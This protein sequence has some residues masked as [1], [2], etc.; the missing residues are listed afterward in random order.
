MKKTLPIAIIATSVLGL[1]SLTSCH[2]EDFD[3]STTV[4][5]ERAFEQSF[6]K[7]FGQ[8]S[9]DQS[10]DF[11]AQKM[12]ALRQNAGLTRATQ[13]DVV[14]VDT[15]ISQPTDEWFTD[16]VD[17]WDGV[18]EEKHDNH[19]VGQNS[20][21]LTSTGDFKIYAVR[22]AGAIE[23]QSQYNLDFGIAYYGADKKRVFVPIFDGKYKNKAYK[24][25][26]DSN[27]WGNPGKAADVS[28]PAGQQFHFYLRYTFPFGGG[29]AT[30]TETF[31]SNESPVFIR[32]DGTQTFTFPE[33][34]GT[35]T[36]LYSTE[37][38]VPSEHVD[39]QVMMIGLE[40]AWG[41]DNGNDTEERTKTGWFDMDFNDIVVI[42]V[43][44]LP[45]P[46][47]KR[48]FAEDLESYDYD[49]ND[50]VFDVSSNGI[51]LRAVGGSLP[52][53]LRITNRLGETHVTEEL[54]EL[55]KSLQMEPQPGSGQP[56]NRLK[57]VT[58]QR[59]SDN[60]TFYK[61][62]DVNGYKINGKPNQNIWL[63]PVQIVN[64]TYLG[65]EDTQHTRLNEIEVEKFGTQVDDTYKGNVELIVLP[66]Y[67]ENYESYDL[68]NITALTTLN[69]DNEKNGPKII[70]MS[71]PGTIPAMWTGTVSTMWMNELTKITLGYRNFFG[72]ITEG[73]KY[74]YWYERD[75]VPGNLYDYLDDEPK[76]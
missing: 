33:F 70:K 31:Y 62:I 68:L 21:T 18:L 28:I 51:V 75:V 74:Y 65:N 73:G 60:K 16:L 12:E 36:L 10:W 39:E 44:K 25:A 48:F 55:M 72:G 23:V 37:R 7:E 40:D 71:S 54:H 4:L 47:S 52:V 64:W 50:V 41:H 76:P 19:T 1:G 69:E 45:E 30:Q 53:F 6:I 67:K 9:A 43:G 66:E 26:C 15:T 63:D 38:I 27:G 2:D 3:V 24:D 32:K 17:Y 49:Y 58:Y 13:D 59:E 8:P 5:Q 56:D 22:Y 34:G 61:S 42:I 29:Y 46:S 14:T 35:S 57:E 11:Y 20:Y